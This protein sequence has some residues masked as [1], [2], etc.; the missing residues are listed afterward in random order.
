MEAFLDP[1][2]ALNLVAVTAMFYVCGNQRTKTI[3]EY[4]NNI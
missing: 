2:L 1:I 4:T 3:N